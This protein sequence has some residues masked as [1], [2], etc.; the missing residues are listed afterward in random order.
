MAVLKIDF[1]HQQIRGGQVLQQFGPMLDVQI[2]QAVPAQQATLQVPALQ[3]V[4]ALIDT[5]ATH[6][7]VDERLAIGLNLPVIDRRQVAGVAGSIIH[8]IY[9]AQ[10]VIIGL[11][12]TYRG[13][14]IGVDL[15]GNCNALI[16]REFL[17]EAIMIYDGIGGTITLCT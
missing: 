9:L 8:N 3:T 10:M 12:M 14:F 16:G 6:S 7:C 13:R 5:G 15:S 1:S 2:G 11:N 4:Y 17:S